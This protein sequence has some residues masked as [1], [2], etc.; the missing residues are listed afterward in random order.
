[1]NPFDLESV[2][3]ALAADGEHLSVELAQTELELLRVRRARGDMMKLLFEDCGPHRIKRLAAIDRYE[4]CALAK[5]KREVAGL[6]Y[7][8]LSKRRRPALTKRTQFP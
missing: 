5:R 4:R 3:L 8:K 1:M 6:S 2:A 7:P